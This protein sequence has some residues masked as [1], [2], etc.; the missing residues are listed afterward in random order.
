MFSNKL[1]LSVTYLVGLV[2]LVM[3]VVSFFNQLGCEGQLLYFYTPP[4][5]L[6]QIWGEQSIGQ[7][8]T[9]PRDN[10]NRVDIRFQTYGR[11][12]TGEITFKLFELPA[13]DSPVE[14]YS[15][16]FNAIS[17]SD[18]RWRTFAFAPVANSAQK[19]YLITLQ[20]PTSRPGNAVTVN[21]V[22]KNIYP[23]GSAF[24]NNAPVLADLTFRVC[25][26]MDGGEKLQVLAEQMTRFRPAWWGQPAF[27]L[28]AAALYTLLVVIFFWQL[29]NHAGDKGL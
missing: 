22:E 14:I 26:Q 12:N 25:F 24:L 3:I 16:S 8:F 20:S 18:Q 5:D 27:Y 21:G 23:P 15:T 28:F 6:Q 2:G 19:S 1:F 10:L 29:T 11:Q 7:S 9:A 13:E 17:L 4:T